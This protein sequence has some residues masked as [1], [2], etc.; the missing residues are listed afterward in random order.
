MW[1]CLHDDPGTSKLLKQIYGGNRPEIS[2]PKL[3]TAVPRENLPPEF[4]DARNHGGG[5]TDRSAAKTNENIVRVPKFRGARSDGPAPIDSVVTRR[6]RAGQ[7]HQEQA[8]VRERVEHYR[9]PYVKEVGECEKSRLAERFEF[10]GGKALPEEMTG[11]VMPIPSEARWKASEERRIARALRRRKGLPDMNDEGGGGVGGDKGSALPATTMFDQVASE[12]E[13][14]QQ[15]LLQARESGVPCDRES[16]AR[17]M[18]EIS[19]RMRE[20]KRLTPSG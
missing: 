20:L 15:F 3:R 11:P 7:I 5:N 13:E 19:L 17:V 14:R 9:P 8:A 18:S 16:E 12:I 6:K 10:G 1:K 2:Y 4:K